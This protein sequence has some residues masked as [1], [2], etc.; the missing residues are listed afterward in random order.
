L[1]SQYKLGALPSKYDKRDWS[2]K[3]VKADF[4]EQYELPMFPNYEQKVG[5]CVAQSVRAIFRKIFKS[6]FGVNFLYGG[7]RTHT[8]GGMHPNEAANFVVTY[9][10]PLEKDDIVLG[11]GS[12]GNQEPVELEVPDVI[13]YYTYNKDKIE[14]KAKPY[15]NCS[16]A[17]L[18]TVNEIKATLLDT[19]LPVMFTTPISSYRTDGFGI[20]NCSG[21]VQGYHEMLVI[22][23]KQVKYGARTED[24][25]VIFN[26]WGEDWGNNGECYMRWEDVLRLGDI[27]AFFP[28]KKKK[29]DEPDDDTHVVVRRTLRK[30]KKDS[31]KDQNGNPYND[32]SP[33]QRKLIEHSYNLG[34]YG[35]DG[36]FGS[37]TRTAVKKF[38][39]D[40]GL[41][42]DGVFGTKSYAVL[43]EL[44]W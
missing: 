1:E 11:K 12:W 30:G 38:Q 19:K 28:P 44:G 33:L 20:L 3:L 40:H 16:W 43:D 8:T 22:G 4:P 39:R 21:S 15:A 6:L 25:A 31:D 34:K 29:D 9:G 26:S 42:A 37:G 35:A 23:W 27:I 2:V 18:Y 7:G 36:D 5:N 32:V 10:L 24:M 17:R 13:D 14:P 41:K